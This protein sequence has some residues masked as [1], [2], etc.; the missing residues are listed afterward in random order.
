MA[1]W[2]LLKEAPP[3]SK[4]AAK[5]NF[6]LLLLSP[7]PKISF[8]DL[9]HFSQ[10]QQHHRVAQAR[11]LLDPFHSLKCFY[12]YPSPSNPL[13]SLVYPNSKNTLQ[14]C[15]HLSI[16]ASLPSRTKQTSPLYLDCLIVSPTFSFFQS[17]L[18]STL[19]SKRAFKGYMFSLLFVG[20]FPVHFNL[21]LS[22]Y[23]P[24]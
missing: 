21:V 15:P 6:F 17:N 24:L 11:S 19:M 1:T 13:T 7:P 3:Y 18:L 9:I 23:H 2:H 4:L 12:F 10:W 22:P 5:A 16:P 8:S 14:I 20:A